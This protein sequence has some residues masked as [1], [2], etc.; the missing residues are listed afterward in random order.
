VRC[1]RRI[2]ILIPG[3]CIRCALFFFLSPVASEWRLVRAHSLLP[4]AF[5]QPDRK[6][7]KRIHSHSTHARGKR[8]T[9]SETNEPYR[10]NYCLFDYVVFTP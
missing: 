10:N 1:P 3:A 4:R 6:H 9:G 8:N 2:L 5:V 7:G